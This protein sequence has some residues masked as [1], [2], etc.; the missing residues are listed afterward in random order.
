MNWDEHV[1]AGVLGDLV[2]VQKEKSK[3]LITSD[4]AM[5]KRYACERP[6]TISEFCSS[7]VLLACVQSGVARRVS[8]SVV[9]VGRYLKYLTKKFLKKHDVR[10]WLRVIASNKD[11]RYIAILT[12]L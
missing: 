9:H 12:C 10:D 4:V 2:K 7:L 5:S 1:H 3:I 8:L 11:R 6:L